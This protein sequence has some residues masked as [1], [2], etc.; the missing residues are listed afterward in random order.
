MKKKQILQ[1]KYTDYTDSKKS[2]KLKYQRIILKVSGETFGEK[3]KIFNKDTIDYIVTQIVAVKSLGVKIG[4]V[5][6]G[7][8][9][10]RGREARWL[11]KVDA[12]YCGMV[13][14]VIN[15]IVLQSQLR[16]KNIRAHLCS[17]LEIRGVAPH[18]NRFENLNAYTSSDVLIFVGGTGNPFF[19][20]DTAA[21]LRAVECG[22]DILIK[23][24]KVEGVYSSDPHKNRTATFYRRLT[25]D[26]VITKKLEIMDSAAFNICKEAH[27]PICVYNFMRYPLS[28]IINGEE[29][30][31]LI[32][33]GG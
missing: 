6:G 8:N 4:I 22:T 9:I 29:I 19:T 5:V 3:T 33:L 27:I 31:T 1:K 13:A 17:S 32:T 14:T 2:R 16:S 23:G 10:I 18:C 28:R 15:G 7:G 20:T 30:G 21:A 26:D 25:F 24:T 11:D 12:D